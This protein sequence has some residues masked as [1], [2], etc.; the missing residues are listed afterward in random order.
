[1][2]VLLTA[3]QGTNK[4]KT[5][6]NEQFRASPDLAL[7]VVVLLCFK[8]ADAIPRCPLLAHSADNTVARRQTRTHTTNMPCQL[9][10]FAC[11]G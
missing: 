4:D 6:T 11:D 1:M 5:R 7:K 3:Q 9:A 8:L 10:R 2:Q